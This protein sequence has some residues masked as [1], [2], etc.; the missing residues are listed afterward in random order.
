MCR[1]FLPYY[2]EEKGKPL[3]Y[4]RRNMGVVTLN[5][6]RIA[7]ES[8]GDKQKF[9]DIFNERMQLMKDALLF[10][11][12]TLKQAKAKNAPIL[13]Q[14]GATGH[15]LSAD[16]EVFDMFKNG[17]AS[18]SIGYIGLYEA[19]TVF[20]GANWENDR[21][22]KEF[23]LDIMKQIYDYKEKWCKETGYGFS[24]Y[25]TPSESLT[26][27]FCR[28]DTKKFGIIK[29]VTD[30][31]YY[32]NSFHYDVRKPIDPF[33]KFEFESEYEPYT[34]GG[35]IHYCEAPS[36]K[37]NLSALE[38]IWDYAYNK[39]GFYGVNQPV[40][41]CF[42]CGFKGE[43]DSSVEGFKCPNCGNHN[44]ETVSCIRRLCG[45]LS[46]VVQRKPIRGRIKEISSRVKNYKIKEDD[47][48]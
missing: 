30:K 10:R 33:T 6:P 39:S 5:I 41:E 31:G 13:Y 18:V 16:S 40:D 12:N 17:E 7:I 32:T 38:K 48:N 37:N 21:N 14:Y 45:Y 25:G 11:V 36:L 23:T 9:W 27:R 44:P 2:E 26:D 22:A 29:D 1:S 42:E 8:K 15:R 24:I 46:S 34:T 35:F 43:F 28:L 19:A 47:N 3:T 20:Y 4:G